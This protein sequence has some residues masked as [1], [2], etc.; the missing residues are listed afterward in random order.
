MIELDTMPANH[1]P[2]SE[3]IHANRRRRVAVNL[4]LAFGLSLL[5]IG[6]AGLIAGCG[7]WHFPDFG[8]NGGG[9]GGGKPLATERGPREEFAHTLL[10]IQWGCIALGVAGIIASFW[11]PL[12]STRHAVG[13]LV[14]GIGVALVRPLLVALYWPTIALVGLAGIAAAWPYLVAAYTWTRSRFL[15]KPVPAP[16]V[17]IVASLKTLVMPR[18]QAVGPRFDRV[19]VGPLPPVSGSDG[20]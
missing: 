1:Q 15:G 3:R 20:P 11:I 16:T 6:A 7:G 17:G 10:Q 4:G 9:L 2:L 13:A 12:I 14:A 8:I 5:A 18:E 19:P